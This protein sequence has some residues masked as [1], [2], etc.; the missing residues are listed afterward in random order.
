MK[1]LVFSNTPISI[2]NVHTGFWN[3][4]KNL[5][6]FWDMGNISTNEGNIILKDFQIWTRDFGKIEFFQFF[7]LIT[8]VLNQI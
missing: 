2:H 4:E 3:Q 1:T 5:A 6:T 7:Y 8:E